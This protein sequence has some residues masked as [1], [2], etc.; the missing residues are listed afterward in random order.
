M[1]NMI[2]MF[3][4]DNNVKA[5]K[6]C[7]NMITIFKL[8]SKVKNKMNFTGIKA[9]SNSAMP[10]ICQLGSAVKPIDKKKPIKKISLKLNSALLISDALV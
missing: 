3:E 9:I 10:S 1:L 8:D 5:G 6:Q 4:L 2:T 7:S